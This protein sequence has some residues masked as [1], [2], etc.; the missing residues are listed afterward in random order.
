RASHP[1]ALRHPEAGSSGLVDAPPVSRATKSAPLGLGCWS[2]RWHWRA[3]SLNQLEILPPRKCAPDGRGREAR[4]MRVRASGHCRRQ[5][6]RG[7]TPSSAS[8]ANEGSPDVD[9]ASIRSCASEQGLASCGPARAR[10]CLTFRS[11]QG[12]TAVAT[13]G[14]DISEYDRLGLRR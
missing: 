8:R 13:P 2:C 4:K 6:L 7:R 11:L 10:I 1:N 5:W 3:L 14:D 9:S 12:G